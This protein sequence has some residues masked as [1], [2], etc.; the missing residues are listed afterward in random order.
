MYLGLVL[1]SVVTK[2]GLIEL[3]GHLFN[4]FLFTLDCLSLY[5]VAKMHN[6][7]TNYNQY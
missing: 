1:P 2:F 4:F 3:T 6:I 5:L 7:T